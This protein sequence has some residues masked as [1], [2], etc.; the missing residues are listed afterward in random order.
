MFPTEQTE[1]NNI[2]LHHR[3]HLPIEGKKKRL[4]TVDCKRFLVPC[5]TSWTQASSILWYVVR[6]HQLQ[7][8]DAQYFPVTD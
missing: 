7:G 1:T 8:H 4:P 6:D 2:R 5:V 3:H